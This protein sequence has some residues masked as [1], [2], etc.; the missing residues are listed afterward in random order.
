MT[1]NGKQVVVHIACTLTVLSDIANSSKIKKTKNM[2]LAGMRHPLQLQMHNDI[3]IQQPVRRTI[4]ALL[5]LLKIVY[6]LNAI[7]MLFVTTKMVH[8]R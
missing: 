6:L 3:F 4:V 8:V 2:F 7:N 1:L 5:I